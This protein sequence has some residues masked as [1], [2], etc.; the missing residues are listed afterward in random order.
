MCQMKSPGCLVWVRGKFIENSNGHEGLGTDKR[1]FRVG[2][3]PKALGGDFD[4]LREPVTKPDTE[5]RDVVVH[6]AG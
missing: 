3:M 2:G 5:R 4:D 6:S 1:G